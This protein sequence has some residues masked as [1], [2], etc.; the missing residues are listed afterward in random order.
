MFLNQQSKPKQALLFSCNRRDGFIAARVAF[1][2]TKSPKR[3]QIVGGICARNKTPSINQSSFA[4]AERLFMLLLIPAVEGSLW[5]CRAIHGQM[6]RSGWGGLPQAV[7]SLAWCVFSWF[8][9]ECWDLFHPNG[10]LSPAEASVRFSEVN[11]F[12]SSIRALNGVSHI[13]SSQQQWCDT[14]ICF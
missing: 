13:C 7:Y 5:N 1:S 2:Q 9:S 6:R 8:F 12:S 11:W 14:W 3:L 4:S 10:D